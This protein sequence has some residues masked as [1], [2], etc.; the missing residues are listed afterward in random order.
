MNLNQLRG[1]VGLCAMLLVA[2][3]L[4]GCGSSKPVSGLKG[5]VTYKGEAVADAKVQVQSPANGGAGVGKTDATGAYTIA[6]L[7]PGKYNVTVVPF[8][9]PPP[10]PLPPNYAP[11]DNP[12]IPKKYR[13]PNTS[14]LTFEAKAGSNEF[15]IPMVD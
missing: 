5:K 12:K 10:A 2:A 6:E 3:T 13:D 15:N 11:K 14:G 1:Y 8:E 4:V 7:P 9:E